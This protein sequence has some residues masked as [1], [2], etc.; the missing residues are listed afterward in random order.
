M[1]NSNHHA[2]REIA[3]LKSRL[4]RVCAER[5]EYKRNFYNRQENLRGELKSALARAEEAEATAKANWDMRNAERA[6]AEY[7]EDKLRNYKPMCQGC[8]CKAGIACLITAGLCGECYT[9]S[10]LRDFEVRSKLAAIEVFCKGAEHDDC[11]Y[12]GCDGCFAEGVLE[13]IG[14]V[15]K[16]AAD[17]DSP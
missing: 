8:S 4:A 3:D 13:I 2:A 5:N 7:M 12:G 6:R 17:D 14:L 9:E 1:N 15:I 10:V 11:D 16:E